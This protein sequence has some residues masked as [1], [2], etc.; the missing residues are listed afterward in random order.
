MAEED[1]ATPDQK[2]NI[3]NY[4]INS[5]PPGQVD[6]V[7]GDVA[8]LC[9]SDLTDGDIKTMVTAYNKAQYVQVEVDGDHKAMVCDFAIEGDQFIDASTGKLLDVNHI[10]RTATSSGE[11]TTSGV[12]EIRKE[13]QAEIQKYLK[14]QY[15]SG[16]AVASVFASGST[17][18]ICISALNKKLIAMWSGGWKG[19][20]KIDV[21]S[22]GATDMS[23]HCKIHV[24]YF[25]DGNVQLHAEKQKEK[26]SVTVG[27][28]GETA[29]S[30][31]KNILT[32]ESDYQNNVEEMYVDM[33][34]TTF[35]SMR[36]MLPKSKQPMT[37]NPAAHSIQ[38]ELG[39]K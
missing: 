26:V 10:D 6:H 2:P 30:I 22:K 25:E 23:A 15:K 37:W 31:V 13:V 5:A 21:G 16:K 19:T 12:E 24:H 7:I 17:L 11:A 38:S 4:F 36:R 1:A 20:F 34:D 39:R 29:K 8:K 32:F 33:H 35:K 3:A 18:T 27:D 9:G 28:A 14:N